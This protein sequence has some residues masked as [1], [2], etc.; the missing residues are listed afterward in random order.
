MFKNLF[1]KGSFFF[2]FPLLGV[3]LLNLAQIHQAS[4]ALPSDEKLEIYKSLDDENS[5]DSSLPSNPMEL[6]NLIQRSSAMDDATPPSDAID[7]ALQ[8][9]DE[10]SEDDSSIKNNLN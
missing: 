8:L 10:Q 2:S 7:Q 9:F 5:R 1:E 3:T 4:Y 6:M